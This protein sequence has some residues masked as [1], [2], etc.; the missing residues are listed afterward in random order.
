M[1]AAYLEQGSDVDKGSYTVAIDPGAAESGVALYCGPDLKLLV[2]MDLFDLVSVFNIA[3]HVT[4]VLEDV[5]ANGFIYGR[6]QHAS[7]AAAAKI[8]Q[9][10]GEVKN[11]QAQIMLAMSKAD[12]TPVLIQPIKGNWG[13]ISAKLGRQV[14]AEVTGWTGKSNK[15]TRSAAYFGYLY[16]RSRA[17]AQPPPLN[18]QDWRTL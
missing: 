3:P 10:V 13:T 1:I 15:D 7:R 5:K 6:N 16:T 2:M 8:S 17:P 11:T 18:P 4:Y 12:V 14:L 9:N